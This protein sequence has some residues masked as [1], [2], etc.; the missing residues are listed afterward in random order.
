MD[1]ISLVGLTLGISAIVVGHISD[2]AV[3]AASG[4][5]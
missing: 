5:Q 4:C 2:S 1:K 3:I